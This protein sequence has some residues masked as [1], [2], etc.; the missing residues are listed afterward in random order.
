MTNATEQLDFKVNEEW[1]K[2]AERNPWA[3]FIPESAKDTNGQEYM[4]K[5]G[6]SI[7]YKVAS[8]DKKGNQTYQCAQCGSE[9]MGAEVA[10]P[11]WDGPFPCS[12]SGRCHYEKVP[13]CP[14]CEKQPNFHGT[15]I[16]I[17]EKVR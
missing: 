5:K 1:K 2:F 6:S 17:G 7:V 4:R 16:E 8:N 14:K 12:G 13:Y 9:I 15:P 10:H 3:S 11:I